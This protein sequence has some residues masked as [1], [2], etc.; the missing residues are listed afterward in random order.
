M[1][2]RHFLLFLAFAAAVHAQEFDI[3]GTDAWLDT[4]LDV[5]AQDELTL[6]GSGT[7]TI[8]GGQSVTPAG[9]KRGFR[10]MLRTY[11]V[12]T[13]GQGALLGRLGDGAAA[14]AFLIG[15]EL[16]WRA[17]KA[18]RLFLGINK[19][20]NDAPKGSFH[21][22]ITFT[23]RGPEELKTEYKLP[24]IDKAVIDKYPRRIQDAQG[25]LGDNTNFLIVGTEKQVMAALK[26]AGWV[27]VDR[28]HGD[29]ISAGI[30]A[31]LSKQAY[32]SLPMSELMFFGRVQDHGMAQGDPIQVIAERHHF[33]IWKAP[34]QVDGQEF[35]VGAGTHD[36]GFDRDA[37]NNGVTH[38]IDP[39]IDKERDYIGASLQES[40]QVAKLDYVMPS[41]PSKEA[42]TATGATFKSDG[43]VLVIYLIPEQTPFST[44]ASPAPS[45]G[46]AGG[47]AKPSTSIFDGAVH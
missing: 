3:A 30:Q 17:P 23:K 45:A 25:N 39:E 15:T 24:T 4:K 42:I 9:A 16:K 18:G 36:I 33:R 35:F 21:V 43:R 31:I 40:G 34:F 38:K 1:D 22:K 5:R 27:E 7:L 10:D 44:P 13:S 2:M 37:R 6:T 14:K 26:A 41:Q 28:S 8:S 19:A 47:P 11:P 29:A 12:N 32:V 46:M 20:G